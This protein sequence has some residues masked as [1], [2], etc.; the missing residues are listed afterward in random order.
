MDTSLTTNS[1]DKNVEVNLNQT[2]VNRSVM[3]VASPMK[4]SPLKNLDPTTRSQD[5]C[6][7]SS[8]GSTSSKR[9]EARRLELETRRFQKQAQADYERKQRELEMARKQRELEAMQL[10][11]QEEM[12]LSN[13]K[14]E[15]K[16]ELEFKQ[17]ELEYAECSSRASTVKSIRSF[18]WFDDNNKNS[19]EDCSHVNSWLEQLD[20]VDEIDEPEENSIHLDTKAKSTYR[21]KEPIPKSFFNATTNSLSTNRNQQDASKE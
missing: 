4:P 11:L 8:L 16:L 5:Y 20:Q 14:S 7:R 15:Q 12:E 9:S 1:D 3:S 19:G 2:L 17:L 21:E 6:P 18:E 13:L 10:Q